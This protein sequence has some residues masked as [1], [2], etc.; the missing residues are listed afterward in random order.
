[1]SKGFYVRVWSRSSDGVYVA[2]SVDG[3]SLEG[4]AFGACRYESCDGLE[5]LGA[6]KSNYVEN[7]AEALSVRIWQYS[8]GVRHEQTEITLKLCFFGADPAKSSSAVTA[9]DEADLFLKAQ[10]SYYA[11]V[12][13]VDGKLVEYWDDYRKRRVLMYLNDAVSM[14]SD[15]MFGFP[16]KEV[17]FKFTNVFGRSYALDDTT[18]SD[19]L[20]RGG[21]DE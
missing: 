5:S 20:S 7:Y 14:A 21:F 10:E 12:D 19:W 3:V 17:Q 1:M 13:A 11:F 18:I 9:E 8:G 16:Y 4:G 15:K 6:L 2:S